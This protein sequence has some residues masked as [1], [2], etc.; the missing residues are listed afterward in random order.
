MQRLSV[1]EC[2]LQAVSGAEDLERFRRMDD[3]QLIR[4]AAGLDA[5]ALEVLYERHHVGAFSLAA[6]IVGSPDRA[7]DVVHEA[8][9]NLWHDARRYD[10]KRGPVRTWLMSMVHDQS[11]DS[12]R[13]RSVDERSQAD[14]TTRLPHPAETDAAS[15]P[16]DARGAVIVAALQALPEGERRIIELAYFGG[17]TLDEIAEVLKLPLDIVKRRARE[18]LLK[19]RDALMSEAP[20]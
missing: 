1:R 18:G 3:A 8:F 2:S 16:A 20:R 12:V 4:L 10:P 7:Q 9:L 17:W 13:R 14:E 19:L 5:S 11:I 6:R 15:R